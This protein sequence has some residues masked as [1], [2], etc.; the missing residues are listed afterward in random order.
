[1]HNDETPNTENN[2]KIITELLIKVKLL[3]HFVFVN[4][5]Q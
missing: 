5:I 2:K 3:Q 4:N 1:M